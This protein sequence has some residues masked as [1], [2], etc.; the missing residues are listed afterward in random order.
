MVTLRVLKKQWRRFTRN[1]PLLLPHDEENDDGDEEG[2]EEQNEEG[3]L[4]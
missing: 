2:E 1:P 4:L 3:D